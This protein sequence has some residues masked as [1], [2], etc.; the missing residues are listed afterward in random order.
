MNENEITQIE[1]ITKTLY[2]LLNGKIPELINLGDQ[3]VDEICQLSQYVNQ[4]VEEIDSLRQTYSDLSN[5]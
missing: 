4:L 5:E 1:S 3:E 2:D